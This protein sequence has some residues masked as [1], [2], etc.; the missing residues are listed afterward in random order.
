MSCFNMTE[1]GAWEHSLLHPYSGFD[2][3][4]GTNVQQN[5]YQMSCVASKGRL[6]PLSQAGCC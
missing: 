6:L 3:R 4:L 2:L 5:P 1:V